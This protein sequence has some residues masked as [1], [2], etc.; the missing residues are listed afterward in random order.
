VVR[1]V[2][3]G[4][5]LIILGLVLLASQRGGAG[6]RVVFGIACLLI[7]GLAGAGVIAARP[8]GRVAGLLLAGVGLMGAA[9]QFSQSGPGG[10]RVL[11]DAFFLA[12]GSSFAWANVAIASAAFAVLSA[13]AGALLLLPLERTR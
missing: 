11:L 6:E 12:A 3:A 5:L 2:L 7:W 10:Q 4:G 9:F 13:L 8:W 1:R